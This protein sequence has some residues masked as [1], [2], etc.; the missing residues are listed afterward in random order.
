MEILDSNGQLVDRLYNG[1]AAANETYTVDVDKNQLASGVYM[2]RLL[3]N[4]GQAL[5]RVVIAH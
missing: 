3:T 2:I 1:H 4:S 5:Q